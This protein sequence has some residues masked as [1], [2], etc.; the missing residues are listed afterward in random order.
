MNLGTEAKNRKILLIL[1]PIGIRDI[2]S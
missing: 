1:S 2:L